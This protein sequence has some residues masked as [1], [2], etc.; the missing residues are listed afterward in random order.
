MRSHR[1]PLPGRLLSL[2]DGGPAATGFVGMTGTV[3]P[4]SRADESHDTSCLPADEPV[5]TGWRPMAETS[6]TG[7]M[8]SARYFTVADGARL[9]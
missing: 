4:D 3:S 8:F 6:A 5:Q 7:S 9:K 1:C 2:S